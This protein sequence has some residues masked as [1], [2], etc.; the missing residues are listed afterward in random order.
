MQVRAPTFRCVVDPSATLAGLS[1]PASLLVIMAAVFAETGLMAGFFLPGDSLL[2]SAGVLLAEG[3]IHLPFALVALGVVV[4]A[5]VGDQI[6]YL[7]GRKT[8]PRLFTRPDSRLFSQRHAARAHDFFLR[9]G[10]KAVVLARFVPIVRTFTPTVA[11]VGAM[12][13]RR[14]VAYNGVGALLWGVGMLAAGHLLGGVTFVAAHVEIMTLAVVT[15]SLLP[16]VVS[17]L[18]ASRRTGPEDI[19]QKISRRRPHHLRQSRA[20]PADDEDVV[21]R[22]SHP[23]EHHHRALGDPKTSDT[24]ATTPSSRPKS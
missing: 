1:G 7:I 3:V 22:P 12:P 16:A 8:G 4:A 9:H 2:F 15:L 21:A 5:F 24:K 18:Q 23:D 6:G 19:V 11:G 10:P 14:F 20:V 17:V 13:Y